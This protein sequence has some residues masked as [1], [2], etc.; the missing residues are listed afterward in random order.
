MKITTTQDGMEKEYSKK[1]ITQVHE[2]VI[3]LRNAAVS[4][5]DFHYSVL[6]SHNIAILASIL[7]QMK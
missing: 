5:G 3:E 7:E 4:Q 2:G 6:L 1:E